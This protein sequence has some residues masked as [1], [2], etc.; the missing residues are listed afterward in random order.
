MYLDRKWLI[1]H[2]KSYLKV[3]AS[4]S[5][6]KKF[7]SICSS[8]ILKFAHKQHCQRIKIGQVWQL[9][10]DWLDSFFGIIQVLWPQVQPDLSGPLR[11]PAKHVACE[12]KKDKVIFE[13][14]PDMAYLLHRFFGYD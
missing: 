9:Q 1:Y 6:Q 12:E 14:V 2:A 8:T 11:G 7:C 13:L 4:E 10:K 3:E 5:Q